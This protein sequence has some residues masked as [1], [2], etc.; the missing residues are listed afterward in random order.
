[1]LFRSLQVPV[2]T[3]AQRPTGASGKLRYNSDTSSYE[4]YN[5]TNGTWTSIGGGATGGGADQVFVENGVTVTTDYTITTNKNALS[6]GP[7]T[8]NSGVAVTVPTGSRW[9]II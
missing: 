5:S 9:V 6:T 2:G 4:G 1:M 7:I 3:T 8:I